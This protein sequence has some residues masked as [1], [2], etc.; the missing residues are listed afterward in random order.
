[1]TYTIPKSLADKAATFPESSHGAC[2]CTLVLRS[3]R[4]IPNVVLAW[5]SEI[6]S[7]GGTPTS[8]FESLP[9]ALS[10]LVDVLQEQ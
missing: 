9:F 6:L 4:H 10:E 5:G 7:V 2:R 8:T 3:G 1:M